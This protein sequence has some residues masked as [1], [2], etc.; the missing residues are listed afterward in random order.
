MIRMEERERFFY[1]KAKKIRELLKNNSFL[2]NNERAR[3]SFHL[4][5]NNYRLIH[6][7]VVLTR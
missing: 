4:A 7:N 6:Q 2:S 3:T 5:L 1:K